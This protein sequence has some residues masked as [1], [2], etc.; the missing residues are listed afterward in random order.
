MSEKPINP[1][2]EDT[3][4]DSVRVGFLAKNTVLNLLGLG[5]PLLVGLMTIPAIVKALGTQ[6]FGILSLIWVVF[7]YFGFFDLGLGRATTKFIAE[8]LGKGERHKIPKYLWT[9]AAFQVVLGF[10]GTLALIL[11]TPLLVEK[12]LNVPQAFIAETKLTFYLIAWALPVTILSMS[13]RGVLEAAQRFDL[14]NA[15]K[16]PASA[17]FYLFPLFGVWM[18]LNLPGIVV[19]LILSRLLAFLAWVVLCYKT[20]PELRAP[21][22]FCRDAVGPLLSFGGWVALSGVI[23]PVIASIDRLLIGSLLTMDSVSFYSAP[24]EVVMR[25]GIIPGSLA[26]TL[27]PA[28]SHLDGGKELRQTQALYGRSTKYL[29][30]VSGAVALPMI[31]LARPILEIWLG[32]EFARQSTLVFQILVFGFLLNSLSSIPFGYLQAVG[33]AD[34]PTKIQ[35]VELVGYIPVLW[36][37]IKWQGIVGAAAAW[38]LR[39][40]A[41]MFLLFFAARKAGKMNVS[42]LQSSGTLR[43]LPIILGI[44]AM[45]LLPFHGPWRIPGMAVLYVVFL[46]LL[47][48]IGLDRNERNW[49]TTRTRNFLIKKEAS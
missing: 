43:A 2:L 34:L 5:L 20:F 1:V 42:G 17:A 4:A 11:M 15:V 9:T 32:P 8:A 28:F 25:L 23:W 46:S 24:Y 31:L 36:I 27:F 44:S 18:G 39:V 33:R 10:V 45:G 22:T 35:L 3:P 13:F 29:L 12:I 38:T 48:F 7:G 6:R 16:I 26:M 14:V 21:I 40:S 41:E 30:I 37:L 47:W 19:L 49:M